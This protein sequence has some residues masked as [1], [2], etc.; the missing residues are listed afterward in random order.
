MR[1]SE[2]ITRTMAGAMLLAAAPAFAQGELS[3]PSLLMRE[4]APHRSALDGASMAP[5]QGRV[6]E[7]TVFDNTNNTTSYVGQPPDGQLLWAN[8]FSFAGTP[9]AGATSRHPT[10]FGLLVFN[11]AAGASAVRIHVQIYS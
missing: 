5:Y 6:I 11:T 8:D 2:V 1:R 10:S 7:T 3:P 4:G 9:W